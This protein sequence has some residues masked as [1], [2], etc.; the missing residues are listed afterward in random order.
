MIDHVSIGV[1]DLDAAGVFYTEV[2]AAAG[3]EKMVDK[4]GTVGFGK[5]YPEFWLNQRP[6]EAGSTANSG[7]HV[8]LRVPSRAVVDE[9]HSRALALGASSDGQPGFRPEYHERYY[10]AFIIDPDGNRVEVVTFPTE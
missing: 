9:F 10:A 5:K 1:T 8:C 4:P 6:A 3:V 2:L 7:N